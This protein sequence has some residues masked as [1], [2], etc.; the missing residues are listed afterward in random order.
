MKRLLVFIALSLIFLSSGAQIHTSDGRAIYLNP[1]YVTFIEKQKTPI[2]GSV[3]LEDDWGKGDLVFMDSSKIENVKVKYNLKTKRFEVVID[4]NV[5]EAYFS[6]V[7]EAHLKVGDKV[8]IMKNCLPYWAQFP[9][10]IHDCDFY[11]PIV[12]GKITFFKTILL[13]KLYANYNQALDVGSTSDKYIKREKYYV[14]KDGQLYEFV[15]TRMFVLKMTKEY[16]D[17]ILLYKKTNYLS[18]RKPNDVAKIFNY[19]NSLC[20]GKS[21]D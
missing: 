11:Y 18:F 21:A 1:T 5:Y 9:D 10:V 13:D 16:R 17:K 6:Q 4:T 7:K 20:D 14:Y 8:Y 3:Y 15:P 2:K 19:Y 12:N